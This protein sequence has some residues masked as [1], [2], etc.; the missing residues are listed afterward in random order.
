MAGARGSGVRGILISVL[1]AMAGG[2]GAADFS[3]IHGRWQTPA[4]PCGQFDDQGFTIDRSG[5]AFFESSCSLVSSKR[6]GNRYTLRQRCEYFENEV[7]TSDTVFEL[8][9]KNLHI[10]NQKYRRCGR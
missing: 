7:E 4:V 10:G 8:R 2:A 3:A 5:A 9:G 1:V 6:S